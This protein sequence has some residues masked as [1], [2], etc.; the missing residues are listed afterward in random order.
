VYCVHERRQVVSVIGG[1]SD[2]L[3]RV[4]DVGC[5]PAVLCLDSVDNKLY[6]ADAGRGW[7]VVIDCAAD[8]V[9]ANLYDYHG[10]AALCY[11][12]RDGKVYCASTRVPLVS[13]IDCDA[14]TVVARVPV[15]RG[16][17]VLSYNPLE[18]KV[19]CAS[20]SSRDSS[21]TVIDGAT[22]SVLAT[23]LISPG[24]SALTYCPQVNKL[25]CLSSVDRAGH[26]TYPCRGPAK[27]A[28]PE[29][30]WRQGLLRQPR[31]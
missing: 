17:G 12:L 24:N 10:T 7:V 14:D 2:T 28:R 5:T 3:E 27:G 4:I 15:G 20:G 1:L 19:Y 13:V 9:V 11:N 26:R 18:N 8:S 22:D 25:Y 31:Q 30:A 29:R 16:P 23:V 6:A 21:L